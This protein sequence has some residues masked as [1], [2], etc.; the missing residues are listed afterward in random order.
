MKLE[1]KL[2]LDLQPNFYDFFSNKDYIKEA[3]SKIVSDTLK[4][5][6][7]GEVENIGISTGDFYESI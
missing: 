6:L 7:K 5:R 4:E 2:I 1:V 3:V